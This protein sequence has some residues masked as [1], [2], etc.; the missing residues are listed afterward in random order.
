[1]R[2]HGVSVGSS[3]NSA[4]AACWARTAGA[5]TACSRSRAC[6][7]WRSRCSCSV[8]AVAVAADWVGGVWAKTSA[9]R[10]DIRKPTA[11]SASGSDFFLYCMFDF[12]RKILAP[13]SPTITLDPGLR[14]ISNGCLHATTQH[15][16]NQSATDFP[17]PTEQR[18]QFFT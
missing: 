14:L 17:P 7:C 1:M 16:K 12:R 6:C 18:S 13:I 3:G 2:K 8:L 9:G 11:P 4:G 5:C 10:C 15:G